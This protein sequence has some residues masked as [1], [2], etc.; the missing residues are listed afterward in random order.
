MA[1]LLGAIFFKL[2]H[3]GKFRLDC[4]GLVADSKIGLVAYQNTPRLYK[5]RLPPLADHYVY[6][7]VRLVY[8]R[9]IDKHPIIP[10][11]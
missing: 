9:L 10:N 8:S 7:K 11:N 6:R 2:A 3:S 4:S 1:F 5:T